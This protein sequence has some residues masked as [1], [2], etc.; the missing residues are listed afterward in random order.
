MAPEQPGGAIDLA[1]FLARQGRYEE[2]ER[3]FSLAEKAFP[4]EARVLFERADTYI[5]G[6]RNLEGARELLKR[7]LAAS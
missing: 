5:R 6:R 3:F 1:R 2:S 4:N 7:Y